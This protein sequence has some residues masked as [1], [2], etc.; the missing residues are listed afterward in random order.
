M[1]LWRGMCPARPGLHYATDIHIPTYRQPSEEF[2]VQYMDTLKIHAHTIS[3]QKQ[4]GCFNIRLVTMVADKLKSSGYD[5]FALV[6]KTIYLGQLT[7][8]LPSSSY[9]HNIL[10]P[11]V[12]QQP[13]EHQFCEGV[14]TNALQ[15]CRK[16]PSCNQMRI[17]DVRRVFS[18]LWL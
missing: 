16:E 3:L 18:V 7:Q 17:K 2:E 12:H 1:V 15:S 11:T 5:R 4:V 13:S 14:I 9:N 6:W 8:Q 10:T